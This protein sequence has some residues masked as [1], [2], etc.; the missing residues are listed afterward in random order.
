MRFTA[1]RSKGQED[2][3]RMTSLTGGWDLGTGADA[4]GLG[5][6]GSWMWATMM[7]ERSECRWEGKGAKGG[8]GSSLGTEG[9]T[10]GDGDGDGD[11]DD[12][13]GD[14]GEGEGDDNDDEGGR[15]EEDGDHD[16]D[17]DTFDDDGLDCDDGY[18][19]GACP[20]T[21]NMPSSRTRHARWA[22]LLR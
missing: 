9:A 5:R 3:N 11:G 15:G 21:L 14:N 12:D 20:S 8:N 7:L 19:T 16:D 17:A 6:E 1:S 10:D 2:G 13:D 18:E 22:S 4:A